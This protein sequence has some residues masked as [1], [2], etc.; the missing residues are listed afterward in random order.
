M[1]QLLPFSFLF[2][3]FLF[4]LALAEDCFDYDTDYFGGDVSEGHYNSVPSAEA[5]QLDCQASSQCLFWTWDAG[6][7][8]ACWH[9]F[10]A[11]PTSGPGLVS[12]PKYCGEQST[13]GP[14]DLTHLRLLSYNMYGWNALEQNPWKAENMYKAIRANNPD[15]MGAQEIND[16]AFEVI[17]HLGSDYKV[18]GSSS[19]GHAIIYRESALTFEEWNTAELYEQD[20]WGL[21]TVE[22]AKFTHKGTGML[23]DH[24]NTHLCVCNGDQLLGSAKTIADTIAANRRPG[25]I[26]I[27]TGDFNVMSDGYENSKA[28]RYLTG[29]LENSPV[30]LVDTFRVANGAN[31]DG[32]TFPG[33]GK[34]DYVLTEASSTVTS[35]AIDRNNY[36]DASDHLPINAV[37]Q[38]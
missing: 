22:W 6:Y 8:G 23:V 21:R 30:V 14:S 31:E 4:K 10:E 3:L 24:F 38:M 37:L 18:A 5:C 34:I 1:G 26:L 9:K 20:E 13:Q 36:G 29:Q 35:A 33:L 11:N 7:N 32:T 16:H 28:I 27:L 15:L 19:A 12:G 25:S 17:G 2:S